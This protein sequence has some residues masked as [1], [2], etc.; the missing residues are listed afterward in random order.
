LSAGRVKLRRQFSFLLEEAESYVN[1]FFLIFVKQ[2]TVP[3]KFL[4]QPLI[5]P[6]AKN[7]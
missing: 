4:L 2:D 3:I 1:L 5:K 6:N 7:I